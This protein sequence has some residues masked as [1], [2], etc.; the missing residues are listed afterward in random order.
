MSAIDLDPDFAI[1]RRQPFPIFFAAEL[2]R[3][4]G[5]APRKLGT[6]IAVSVQTPDP[7]G[8][9]GHIQRI[10]QHG[11]LAGHLLQRAD[12]GGEHRNAELHGLQR[13]QADP[14]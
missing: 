2:R 6:Q 14:S 10:D 4:R 1:R 12:V 7:S 8:Q 5:A 3:L 9:L 11:R 13:G